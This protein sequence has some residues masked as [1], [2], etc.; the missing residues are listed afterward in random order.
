MIIVTIT[1]TTA[2][3]TGYMMMS[4][5]PTLYRV[6]ITGYNWEVWSSGQWVINKSYR[7]IF[8]YLLRQWKRGRSNKFYVHFFLLLNKVIKFSKH[9]SIDLDREGAWLKIFIDFI[10][11]ILSVQFQYNYIKSSSGA[12]ASGKMNLIEKAITGSEK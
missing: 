6:K 9:H 4:S 1:K 11:V 10:G 3:L 2:F 5:L 7:Q 12:N 8:S